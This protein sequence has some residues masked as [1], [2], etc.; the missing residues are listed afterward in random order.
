MKKQR[1]EDFAMIL[2][3]IEGVMAITVFVEAVK[4]GP[5]LGLSWS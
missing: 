4:F 1:R 3:I 5:I 2:E